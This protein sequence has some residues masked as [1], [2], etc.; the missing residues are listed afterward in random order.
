[1]DIPDL[2]TAFGINGRAAKRL[3]ADLERLP[4]RWQ[5]RVLQT[6]RERFENTAEQFL[7]TA[8]DVLLRL[9]FAIEPDTILDDAHAVAV[10]DPE[11][12]LWY[13]RAAHDLA[14]NPEARAALDVFGVA[15]REL[16]EADLRLG[17]E[18]FMFAPALLR[19]L[20][21]RTLCRLGVHVAREAPVV[22]RLDTL[23]LFVDVIG[24]IR[25][26]ETARRWGRIIRAW[27]L[28]GFTATSVLLRRLP[29]LHHALGPKALRRW[30][31]KGYRLHRR[32]P[33][34]LAAFVAGKTRAAQYWFER[35]QTGL[36]LET[37]KDRLA[38]YVT[39]HAGRPLKIA[40][41]DESPPSTYAARL[42]WKDPD[43]LLLPARISRTDVALDQYLRLAA[44]QAAQRAFGGFELDTGRL[45]KL[46]EEANLGPIDIER[47]DLTAL[48]KN[49][50]NAGLARDLLAV[51]E[52][53]RLEAGLKRLYPGLARRIDRLEQAAAERPDITRLQPA[54]MVVELTDR[55]LQGA[56]GNVEV[57]PR[58]AELAGILASRGRRLQQAT[59][60]TVTDS[61]ELTLF[62]YRM[63]ERYPAD[64]GQ[65]FLSQ[66]AAKSIEQDFLFEATI[67]REDHAPEG[68]HFVRSMA[69]P[70]R[71]A[72]VEDLAVSLRRPDDLQRAPAA[73]PAVLYDEWDETIGEYCRD[74]VS[75]RERQ[76]T[77]ATTDLVKEVLERR[78]GLTRRLRRL[79]Q[80]VR[81]HTPERARRLAE[82]QELDL[83]RYVNF[84][85]EQKAG[86]GPEP[87]FYWARRYHRREIASALLIDLS[88]STRT[89]VKKEGRAVIDVAKEGLILLAEAMKL[90]GD[91]FALFGY[92]G[93]GRQEVDFYVIKDFG[94]AYG[95][96]VGRRIA[97]LTPLAQ[98]RDGAA[99][100]HAVHRL[101]D[102]P[103]RRRLLMVLSDARPDDYEYEGAYAVADTRRAITEARPKGIHVFGIVVRTTKT[104]GQRQDPYANLPHVKIQNVQAL[105]QLLPS[106]YRR[107]TT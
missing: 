89:A 34:A 64:L 14:L 77:P 91:Q 93:I 103:A 94:Q 8:L 105:P 75:L 15:G 96:D 83:D 52:S 38:A 47:H 99:I 53:A 5:A 56:Y 32:R 74:H 61:A 54:A 104:K 23:R 84:L 66:T 4:E 92:S 36:G 102:R 106:L 20:G 42:D 67:R 70:D 16:A 48:I 95:P 78:R 37:I 60:S 44:R 98:N 12:A 1:M 85:A 59:D 51:F 82:G 40:P 69:S 50:P 63:L 80:I 22:E 2:Q 17:R 71:A 26:K 97:A 39:S 45:K 90:S 57:P 107:L 19:R 79:W 73:G 13:L 6:A 62:A 68:E 29:E 86:L 21:D 3:T 30:L 41:L 28:T 88:G 43:R 7:R 46:L 76:I 87:D 18:F 100:R 11:A 55:L 33:Q 65:K 25:P 31:A 58:V 10:I 49:F 72:E 24:S 101:I 81:P 9:P 35:L 27:A